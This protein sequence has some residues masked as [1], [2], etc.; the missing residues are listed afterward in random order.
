MGKW[1][2]AILVAVVLIAAVI[3]AI[4]FYYSGNDNNA[5]ASAAPNLYADLVTVSGKGGTSLTLNASIRNTGGEAKGVSVSLNSDAFGQVSSNSINVPA[6]QTVYVQCEAQ[7]Q[8]VT[9]REYGVTI[10]VNYN[11]AATVATNNN[12][13]FYVLP[14]V[15]ITDVHFVT[16]GGF[17]GIGASAKSTI[18]Q[19]DN[20]T[21][22]FEITSG[23]STS[24][25]TSI[26]ATATSPQGT[27]GLVITPNPVALADI[28]P[29]GQSNEYSFALSTH[30]TPN[31]K[32]IITIQ[33]FS[34]QYEFASDS[35]KTLTVS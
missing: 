18:G 17:L 6:N 23:S 34:G 28:G 5:Q 16:V 24:T 9:N 33:L 21:L 1:L 7:I 27:M 25:Y 32:Y 31:G 20:T 12:A 29:S 14:S 22:F 30:N 3:I 8:D 35:S 19:N 4:T 11:G 15:K 13:Q 2:A 10:N 26:S